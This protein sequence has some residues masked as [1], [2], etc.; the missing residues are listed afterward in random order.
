VVEH[1]ED[2]GG[3]SR[4]KPYD[5]VIVGAGWA[6]LMACKY[7]LAEGLR[8]IVLERRDR[9]GG[10]WAYSDD[11]QYGGVMKTTST[12]SSRCITEISDFPMPADYPP[13]PTHS[14]INT[15]LEAYCARFSL[16]EHLRFN[17]CVIRIS[18]HGGLW[19]ITTFDG[20]RWSASHVIVC[21]GVHQQPNDVS[22]DERFSGY[23]GP[24]VP[25]AA[26]KEVPPDW[27]NKTMAVWGGGETAS[28]VA[29]EASQ[30]ASRVYWCIP[31]GQWFVPKV[32]DRL[33][34]FPGSAP[35]VLDH[36]SSRLRLWLSPTHRYSPFVY[37]YLEYA[38]GFNGHG[39]EEWR[40]A[41]PY[42]RSFLNKTADVLPRVKS[43]RI[44]PKRDIASCRGRTVRFSDGTTADIDGIVACSGYRIAFPFFDES[45]TPGAD[46]RNWFKYVFYQ[47]DPS[48]AFVGF[49]RPV[50]GS[51]PGIAELQGRYVAQVFSG[52]RAPPDRGAAPATI[53]RD[54]RFWNH[55]FRHSS[56]RIAGLV[57]HFVYSDQIAR[58]IGCYPQLWKL[59][60][61]SPRR[62][63]QAV[64][65]PWNGCQFWLNDV[66]HHERIFKTLQ[67]YHDNRI[68]QVW[69][70]VVLAPI[71]PLIT[72][73]TYFQVFLREHVVL[74]S[75]TPAQVDDHPGRR[76]AMADGDS[77]DSTRVVE[78]G[79][80]G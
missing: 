5:V 63:W 9:V 11:P 29:V 3:N 80:P 61:S 38:F 70:F 18:K 66:E 49:V 62:W 28:D 64:T 52:V 13:F 79:V 26:V 44:V 19:Q 68:S 2:A 76:R 50:F 73:L 55:H 24:L 22:G 39:Q 75:R 67:Q 58:L 10:V 16:T 8:T 74:G 23:S 43:G 60:F 27:S 37:Q 46:P 51:I 7:C 25:A 34:P 41:A 6:G 71:L 14:Q 56:L 77:S 72:L 48:L 47:D 53:D 54:A 1:A 12:T 20:N 21:S 42:Q 17:Q 40:T 31:N 78:E 32:V 45:V 69:V 57:D 35:K 65:A 4:S 15:Y 30:V 59:F 36:T 33:P